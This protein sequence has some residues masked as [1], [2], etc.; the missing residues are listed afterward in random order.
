MGPREGARAGAHAPQR[1]GPCWL[2]GPLDLPSTR[3]PFH[4]QPLVGEASSCW[5]E[6]VCATLPSVPHCVLPPDRTFP[7]C[8][9]RAPTPSVLAATFSLVL[10]TARA[11]NLA[12]PFAKPGRETG[13][14]PEGFLAR[15]AE[16]GQLASQSLPR[17]Q[18]SAWPPGE[19]S[20]PRLG[21]SYDI[22]PSLF[23]E[24]LWFLQCSP[25]PQPLLQVPGA[26]EPPPFSP[27]W[28]LTCVVFPV[29]KDWGGSSIHALSPHLPSPGHSGCRLS[30][31]PATCDRGFLEVTPIP[32][33]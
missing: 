9:S 28:G 25:G 33:P 31:V 7:P 19:N 30:C 22:S 16:R 18:G 21:S 11:K 27:P 4:S 10:Q 3:G 12:R 23:G 24:R 2:C 1:S 32:T 20:T 29:V 13:H 6:G 14:I 26:A 17:G 15:P 8:P 5:R